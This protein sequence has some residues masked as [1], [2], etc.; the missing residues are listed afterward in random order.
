[1]KNYSNYLTAAT[2][3]WVSDLIEKNEITDSDVDDYNTAR[4]IVQA[5]KTNELDTQLINSSLDYL[6]FTRFNL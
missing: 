1:M 6:Y 2:L 5:I 3:K 4:E